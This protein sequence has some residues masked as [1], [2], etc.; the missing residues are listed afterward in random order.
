[1]FGGLER[2]LSAI[3]K[4]NEWSGE[5][6]MWISVP[7]T[8]FVFAEVVAR[9][10]FNSPTSWS[11][12]LTGYLFGALSLLGGAYCMR[13]DIHVRMNII[14]EK[15]SNRARSILDLCTSALIFIFLFALIYKGGTYAYEATCAMETS[16]TAWDC[17]IW[18]FFIILPS[19]AFLMILQAIRN[20]IT[21][22]RTLFIKG[23]VS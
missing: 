7:L 5:I 17:P 10:F 18:P 11:S 3:D 2:I 22:L 16:G 1:M 23:D 13:F 14:R 8:G 4:I 6:V 19:A 21:D 20:M 12:E 15:L 9:Y